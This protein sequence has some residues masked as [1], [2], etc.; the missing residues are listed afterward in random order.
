M[1]GRDHFRA[2][3]QYL[4][5]AE[6]CDLVSVEGDQCIIRFRAHAYLAFLALLAEGQGLDYGLSL[7]AEL[8]APQ[9]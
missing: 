1:T 4:A 8:A 3:E 9:L 5:D 7:A 2:A 6:E